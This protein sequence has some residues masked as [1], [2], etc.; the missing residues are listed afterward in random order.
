MLAE[1][2]ALNSRVIVDKLVFIVEVKT[3]EVFTE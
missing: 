2:A 1:F 3:A